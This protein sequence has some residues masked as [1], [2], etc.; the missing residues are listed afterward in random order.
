MN[1]L[2]LCTVIVITVIKSL[3]NFSCNKGLPDLNL[4]DRQR[5]IF[6]MNNSNPKIVIDLKLINSLELVHCLDDLNRPEHPY[7]PEQT[8]RPE[9]G[10][11]DTGQSNLSV[12]NLDAL[13]ASNCVVF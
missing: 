9:S 11:S 8:K 7:R 12:K 2:K 13:L 6:K 1:K 10:R 4:T 5:L 3:H